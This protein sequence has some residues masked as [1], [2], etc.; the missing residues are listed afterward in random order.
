MIGV[1]AGLAGGGLWL[2]LALAAI[3]AGTVTLCYAELGSMYPKAGA[4]YD[5]LSR[6]VGRGLVPYL[7]GWA[8]TLNGSASLAALALGFG[9]YLNLIFPTA[10]PLTSFLLIVVLT[11]GVLFGLKLDTRAN[12]IFTAIE[13]GGLLIIVT[14]GI[15]HWGGGQVLELPQGIGGALN[16][17]AL[18]FFAYTGFED[19]SKMGEEVLNPSRNFP[20]G[21]LLGLG[22]TSLLYVA[23]GLAVVQLAPTADL[24]GSDAPLSLAVGR[25]FGP[26]GEVFLAVVALFSITNTALFV[27]VAHSRLIYAMARGGSLP[28]G[29]TPILPQTAVPWVAT[30]VAGALATLLL[31]LGGVEVAGSI[32]SWS[33]L[34]VYAT[35]SAALI[36]LRYRQPHAER[37][38]RVPLNIGNF[39]VLA[40]FAIVTTLALSFRFDW[41]IIALSAGVVALGIVLHP[42]LRRA[43][44]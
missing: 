2:A 38:F 4:E 20:I 12:L 6:A 43:R 28:R 42:F 15:A 21:L 10:T 11:V 34:L 18:L 40:A 22:L 27:L 8:L 24:A 7:V 35:V 41:Q 9:Q 36:L 37:P 19:A 13:V 25:V 32:A 3:V 33:A 16:A 26:A 29:L 31:P 14:L 23:L 1:G 30:L 5:F 17:T 44:D 39:P